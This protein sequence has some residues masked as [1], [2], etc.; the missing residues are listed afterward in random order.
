MDISGDTLALLLAF[1]SG[2]LMA[3]QGAL[4]SGLSKVIGLLET[5]FVVHIT[6][7]ILIML[8]LFAMKMGK[9]NLAAFGDAPWYVY[10]GGA[11]GVGIIY[12][13]AASIPKVGAANATT[14]IIVGQV[15][16]AIIIDHFG[17]FGLAQISYGWHQILGLILL[18]IGGKLLLS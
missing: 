15:L 5:T 11:I 4:N 1:V 9:G 13:V 3:V 8:L 6:G 2:I 10:L 7:T 14:A 12:L 17:M 16:T 18:A